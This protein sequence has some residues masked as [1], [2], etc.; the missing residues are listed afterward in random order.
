MAISGNVFGILST[1]RS[2]LTAN[3]SALQVASNNA[4][5]A[6]TEGFHKRD[7]YFAQSSPGLRV[8]SV[9][10]RFDSYLAARLLNE[11]STLGAENSRANILRSVE[12]EFTESDYGLGTRVDDFFNSMRALANAP[13]DMQFRRDVVAKADLMASAFQRAASRVTEEQRQADSALQVVVNQANDLLDDIARLNQN[14][15]AIEA[16]NGAEASALRDERDV[17]INKLATLMDITTIETSTG[18]V[19]VLTAGGRTIVQDT[20]HASLALTPDGAYGGFRRLDLVENG[21]TALDITASLRDGEL[22]GYLRVRDDDLPSLMTRIDQLSHDISTSVN[23]V[24]SAGFGLDGVAGRN[25]FTPPVAVSG[26]A[27]NMSLEANFFN[28][29][30]WIGASTTLADAVGGNDNLLLLHG[31]DEQALSGGGTRTFAEEYGDII[32][33]VGRMVNSNISATD[34]ARSRVEQLSSIKESRTGVSVDEEMIDI[35]RFQRAYQ[36]GAKII[37]TVDRLY[38]TIMTLKQ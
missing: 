27:V 1:G 18:M 29:P 20:N 24:Q 6:N 37:Q 32:S 28:N 5:N 16:S 19:Q 7:T 3:T 35:T 34:A 10:R 8:E 22:G 31:L 14:V 25:M 36:A 30:G 26:A 38:D 11:S 17:R 15:L 21:G 2:S 9:R 23:A 33:T 4:T 13:T 12:A